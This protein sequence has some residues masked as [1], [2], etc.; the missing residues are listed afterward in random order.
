VTE[1]DGAGGDGGDN[2][3]MSQNN[4]GLH[5]KLTRRGPEKKL[6]EAFIRRGPVEVAQSQ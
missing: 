3:E 6:M 5:S 2:Q 4:R 1:N